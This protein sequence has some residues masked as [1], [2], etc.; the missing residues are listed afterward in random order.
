[1]CPRILC[2]PVFLLYVGADGGAVEFDFGVTFFIRQHFLFGP[3]GP[4]SLLAADFGDPLFHG[5]LLALDS[6]LDLIGQDPPGQEA[7]ERLASFLLALDFDPGRN[8]FQVDARFDFIDVLSAFALRPDELLD[9]V[10]LAHSQ[11]LQALP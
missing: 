3:L 8:M 1:M 2:V 7:V 5:A 11:L 10:V 4:F 9:Q 6:R